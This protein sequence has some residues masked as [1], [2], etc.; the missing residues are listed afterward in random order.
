MECQVNADIP[1]LKC[2]VR[3]PFISANEGVEEAYAFGL[4]SVPG[5]AMAFHVMLKSGAHYRHVPIH[6][7]ALHPDA[8]QRPLGD[9][10]LWDCFTFTPEVHVFSYL[11]DHEC[12]AHMRSGDEDGVYLFTIDWLPDSW[13]QPGW[14]L[15]P[16]QNKCG[17]VLALD[18]GNLACLPTNRISWRD[19]Y[20]IGALPNP[21]VRGYTVQDSTY[22]S[23]D[24]AF[25]VSRETGMY[26]EAQ[27]D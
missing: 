17:H 1:Y 10:Q 21:R 7:L 11:R 3:L 19:A 5:R 25:D 14:V 16:D 20:F 2:W 12:I 15:Q 4:S 8:P 13:T 6:A 23:E 27:A 24:S 22:Q 18:D 26:Y 9:C